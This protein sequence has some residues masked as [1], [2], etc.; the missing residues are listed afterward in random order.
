MARDSSQSASGNPGTVH[1]PPRR[2][3]RSGHWPKTLPVRIDNLTLPDRIGR[4]VKLR[5]IGRLGVIGLVGCGVPMPDT[6][7]TIKP[8][9]TQQ[10]P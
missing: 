8:V 4:T 9:P 7:Y 10:P 3:G 1:Y 2:M 6:S 5:V